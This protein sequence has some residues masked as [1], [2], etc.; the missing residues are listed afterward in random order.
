MPLIRHVYDYRYN[1]T[2]HLEAIFRNAIHFWQVVFF[3]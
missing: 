3:C 2:V 1:K